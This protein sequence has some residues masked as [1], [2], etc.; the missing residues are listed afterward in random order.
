M[1]KQIYVNLPV[2][3]LARS[4]A[5]FSSLGYEF[6]PQFSN[7]QGAC[8]ILGENIFAMLLAEPFFQ[9]FTSKPISN[10]RETTEVL[11]CIS[12]ESREEV[13]ALVAKALAAG[14]R[15]PNPKQDHGFMYGHGFEDLDGHVWELSWMDMSAVPPRP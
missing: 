3:D 13:D 5:F 1:H 7:D 14:G 9:S 11:T 10:A 12:C 4:R 8:M 15:A 2:K 6:N